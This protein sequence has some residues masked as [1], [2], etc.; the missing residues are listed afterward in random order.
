[1]VFSLKKKQ[2][3]TN[4]HLQKYF[5][6]INPPFFYPKKKKIQKKTIQ[7]IQNTLKNKK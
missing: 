2:T 1:M 5:S 6:H 3:G 4:K 7:T